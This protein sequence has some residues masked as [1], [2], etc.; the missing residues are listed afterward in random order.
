M[1]FS[2]IF[3]V[4]GNATGGSNVRFALCARSN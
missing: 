1:S 3:F 2:I 4:T